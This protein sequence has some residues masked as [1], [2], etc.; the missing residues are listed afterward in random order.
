MDF[1][2]SNERPICLR[3]NREN[4]EDRDRQCGQENNEL[5]YSPLERIKSILTIL[6]DKTGEAGEACPSEPKPIE[7]SDDT[8]EA[9]KKYEALK[10]RYKDCNCYGF[11]TAWI[12]IMKDIENNFDEIKNV[13]NKPEEQVKQEETV[14]E[15]SEV[16]EEVKEE[17]LPNINLQDIFKEIVEVAHKRWGVTDKIELTEPL[18]V[19]ESTLKKKVDIVNESVE[20]EA[21]VEES[22]EVYEADCNTAEDDEQTIINTIYKQF[23]SIINSKEFGNFSQMLMNK[24]ENKTAN[25]LIIEVKDQTQN[26]DQT[27]KNIIVK[28]LESIKHLFSFAKYIMNDG[29]QFKDKNTIACDA[30]IHLL[31][32]IKFLKLFSESQGGGRKTRR[33]IKKKK[34]YKKKYIKR[35]KT[36]NNKKRTRKN[37]KG[38]DPFIIGICIIVFFVVIV[39]PWVYRKFK[40]LSYPEEA[41]KRK[42]EK[43]YKKRM[44]KIEKILKNEDLLYWN[45]Q[46]DQYEVNINYYY[47][48]K[49]YNRIENADDRRGDWKNVI[50]SLSYIYKNDEDV[51]KG[52]DI[53]LVIESQ[54]DYYKRFEKIYRY[55]IEANKSYKKEEMDIEDF[56][57][58]WVTNMYKIKNYINE[59]PSTTLTGL[60]TKYKNQRKP[61]VWFINEDDYYADSSIERYMSYFSMYG[62]KTFMTDG[63]FRKVFMVLDDIDLDT[64]KEQIKD[65]INFIIHSKENMIERLV[66]KFKNLFLHHQRNMLK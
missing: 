48:K 39:V 29:R 14:G 25:D 2:C 1:K 64:Q 21:S 23:N 56:F 33:R 44:N 27:K 42:E 47:K 66:D 9:K 40:D 24:T 45:S 61:D 58:I 8:D 34:T 22:I 60:V 55:Y 18:H 52:Y 19:I 43:I 63:I 16:V 26:L 28:N 65:F 30:K 13:L 54:L 49:N 50:K 4:R 7:T 35:R 41:E 38:G 15:E 10:R 53:N 51:K 46:S 37:Y 17:K 32:V 57:Y 31:N 62:I 36:R 12:T 6:N 11:D 3:V 20:G 59:H 5:E